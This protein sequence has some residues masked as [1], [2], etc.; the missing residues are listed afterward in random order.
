MSAPRINI[1]KIKDALW[2]KLDAELSYQK[3]ADALG[4]SKGAVT[5]YVGQ[6]ATAGLDCITVQGMDEAARELRLMI[7]SQ[8]VQDYLQRH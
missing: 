1:P 8:K 7:G 5:K 4:L 6:A 2:I 3:V